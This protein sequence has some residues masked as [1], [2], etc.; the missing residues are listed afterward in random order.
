MFSQPK[1]G[2][3]LTQNKQNHRQKSQNKITVLW[4]SKEM[5]SIEVKKKVT[6]Y[7]KTYIKVVVLIF[8]RILASSFLFG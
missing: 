7:S 2:I 3:C 5:E 4:A 8:D 1:F 6:G